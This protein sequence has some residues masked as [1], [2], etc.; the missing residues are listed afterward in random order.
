VSEAE[1]MANAQARVT[2]GPSPY[3]GFSNFSGTRFSHQSLFLCGKE[4]ARFL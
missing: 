2:S 3:R 1:A 4:I